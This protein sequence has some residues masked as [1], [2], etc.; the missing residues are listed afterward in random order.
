[1]ALSQTYGDNY[2]GMQEALEVAGY[3]GSWTISGTTYQ[4]LNNT[5]LPDGI[6]PNGNQSIIAGIVQSRITA[7][8]W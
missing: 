1:V 2:L 5:L 6:H 8:G 7:K 4:I 3:A